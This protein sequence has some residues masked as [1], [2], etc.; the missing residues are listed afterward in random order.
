MAD[1]VTVSVVSH[2]QAGLAAAVL[3][4]LARRCATPLEVVL[5]L[6]IPEAPPPLP[7]RPGFEVRVVRNEHPRGF[8]A[9]H[10][11]AAKLSKGDFFCVLNPD[12]RLEADPFPALLALFSDPALAVA[13]PL[14]LGPEGEV[15]DS[16]RRYP[17]FATLARKALGAAPRIDYPSPSGPIAVDWVAGMFMLFRRSAFEQVGGFDERYFLYYEDA[18]LCRRLRRRGFDVRLEP[19]ARATHFARRQSRREARYLRWHLASMMRFLLTR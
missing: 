1:A 15:E 18:D 6:N 17:T 10:N 11:T 5:T 8:G 2:G 16:A 7:S 3:D 4:D 14:I 9:N 13:A 12:I 19:R